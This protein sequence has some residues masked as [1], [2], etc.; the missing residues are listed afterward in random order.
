MRGPSTGFAEIH[1]ILGSAIRRIC[2]RAGLAAA[3]LS[4]ACSAGLGGEVATGGARAVQSRAVVTDVATPRRVRVTY[5]APAECPGY[6]AYVQHVARRSSRLRL[7]P[8]SPAPEPSRVVRARVVLDRDPS[9][10]VGLLSLDGVDALERRVQGDRCEDVVAALALITVLRLERSRAPGSAP[11]PL[12]APPAS[13]ERRPELARRDT[14]TGA[15]APGSA[16]TKREASPGPTPQPPSEGKESAR[17]P[18]PPTPTAPRDD[19]PSLPERSP[20]PVDAGELPTRS[21]PVEPAPA[22]SEPPVPAVREPEPPLAQPEVRAAPRSG[23]R[24]ESMP[25]DSGGHSGGTTRM[26]LVAHIGYARV[27]ADAL[28]LSLAGELGA[29]RANWAGAVSLALAHGSAAS[30][31]GKAALTLLTAQLDV[32]PPGVSVEAGIWF[33][34]CAMLRGG[35]IHVSV[36]PVDRPLA[37]IGALRP[38]VALGPSLKVGLPLSSAWSVRGLAELSFQLVRDRFDSQPAAALGSSSR[39][40]RLYRPEALSFELGLGLAYTF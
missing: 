36:S 6:D 14:S 10:W 33:Q 2:G 4:L 25:P 34:A 7:E 16:V 15:V 11:A 17:D 37:S 39:R 24:L 28:K 40:L 26:S 29:D 8:E 23:K 32:C 31:A 9:G 19:A 21:A 22:A 12:P 38:W 13:V 35:A 3:G 27:P 18:A 1:Q 5:Q 20:D 30:A